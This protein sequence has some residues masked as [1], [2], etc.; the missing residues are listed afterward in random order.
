MAV[1]VTAIGIDGQKEYLS[2]KKNLLHGGSKITA[3]LL[4][5]LRYMYVWHICSKLQNEDSWQNV[6]VESKFINCNLNCANNPPPQ[7]CR[8]SKRLPCWICQHLGN[9]LWLQAWHVH[10]PLLAFAH[11]HWTGA[12]K[13]CPC[14][15]K[16]PELMCSFWV[17]WTSSVDQML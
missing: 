8:I 1:G 10:R 12:A 5:D 4:R 17:P 6:Y 2:T 7:L 15:V 11:L 13:F 14:C 16:V 9:P 3:E